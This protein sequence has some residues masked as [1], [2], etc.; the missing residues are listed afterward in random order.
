VGYIYIFAEIVTENAGKLLEK[1]S[2]K[3]TDVHPR[4]SL[5]Y[6]FI[7]MT[8]FV[9]IFVFITQPGLPELT[10]AVC[11]PMGLMVLIS[12]IGNIL[13]EQSLKVNDLSLREP[14]SNLKPLLAGFM[15]YL[16]FPEERNPLLLVALILGAL[17]VMWGIQYGKSSKQQ[18]VGVMFLA[19]AIVF[20][21]MLKNVYVLVL[22]N[23][24]PEIISLVRLSSIL[25]LLLLFFSPKKRVYGSKE[26][27][28]RYVFSAGFLYAA[29]SIASLYA[30]QSLGLV[31][32]MLFMLLGPALR[33][34][35]AY[36]F[37]G[38]EPDKNKII[39]SGLLGLIAVGVAFI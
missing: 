22:K 28:K 33:Y 15:G 35:T 24:S 29:G 6:R 17:I 13:D 3:T 31:V 9:G 25:F 10:L 7:S 14:L 26:K 39:S 5:Q 37:L 18:K 30:I 8:L 21:A 23:F 11:I 16:I 34:I 20:S 4:E 1:Y 2:Y 12:F 36:I 32:T 38:D 27:A 19:G